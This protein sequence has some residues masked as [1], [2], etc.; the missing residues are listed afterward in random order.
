MR[1]FPAFMDLK[2]RSCLVVGGGA[3]AA[4]KVRPLLA[5]GAAVTVVAP[6]LGAD[7]EARRAASEIAWTARGFVDGDLSGRALAIS[8]TGSA[9]VDERVAEAARRA[10]VPVNVVDRSELCSFVFPAIVDRD[11]LV[12]AISSGGASPVLAR[13]LR[14]R[15]EAL[16]PAG[17][18]R[19]ARFAESFRGAVAANIRDF[20]QRRRF[21]EDFFDGPIA[22]LVQG[23]EEGRAREAMISLVNRGGATAAGRVQ[24][25]GAG[26]GDPDL[27]TLK[28]LRALQRAD[29]ILYDRLVAP[30]ILDLARRDAEL[31]PV[32]KAKGHHSKTQD[33]INAL[34]LRHAQAGH[35]VVRL[36]G[37]DPFIFGR[38]GEEQA[39]LAARGI[40]VEVVPGITAAAGCAAAAG[41]P[42]THRE[43]A[44]A[45]TFVTGHGSAG[46]PELDWAG[47]ASAGQ[48]LAIY[49][50]LSTAGVISRRLIEHGL[51]PGTPVAVI[52]NGTRPEEKRAFGRLGDLEALLRDRAIEGPALIV[53]GEVV[54]LAGQGQ[55][56]P[57]T[58]ALRAVAV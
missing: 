30:A 35:D 55:V 28:A 12:V 2:G 50:G 31:V 13:R 22:G 29:V 42:L 16:L 20:A 32:G 37:G 25:V 33:E 11:P 19:L 21:W 27:L 54:R 7:L 41:I 58:A 34:L 39:Y 51:E 23:G 56:Q 44:H 47:L 43:A 6:R 26:P 5:A 15:L 48:T 45:V 38:G 1:Y 52:E 10:G 9:A 14:E 3:L 4:R 46:E 49:M 57:E 36:K 18:G 8:A 24:L 40:A 17:L 53:V